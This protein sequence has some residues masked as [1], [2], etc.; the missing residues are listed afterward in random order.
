MGRKLLSKW[1]KVETKEPPRNKKQQ[2]LRNT[3]NN[4]IDTPTNN[5]NTQTKQNQLNK[6]LTQYRPQFYQMVPPNSRLKDFWRKNLNKTQFYDGKNFRVCVRSVC[7]N[8]R[9]CQAED[10]DAVCEDGNCKCS[11][12]IY[13]GRMCNFVNE[14]MKKQK[15][16]RRNGSG[17]SGRKNSDIFTLLICSII[18]LAKNLI[19]F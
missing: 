10:T 11:S 4:T 1:V 15:S 17:K 16:D 8:H 18:I 19:G 3:N 7:S 5:K 6:K 2:D 9:H 12:R 13:F 14:T